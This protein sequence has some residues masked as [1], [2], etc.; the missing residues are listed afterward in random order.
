MMG[1]LSW[2]EKGN[3]A[4]GF[5]YLVAYLPQI[6]RLQSGKNEIT[7]LSLPHMMMT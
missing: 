5:Q 3:E 7:P 1:K 6:I 4:Y 2:M